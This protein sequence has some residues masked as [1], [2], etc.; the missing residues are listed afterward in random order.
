M[1]DGTQVTL[2]HRGWASL[3]D[4]HPVRHGHVGPDFSRW[5]GM[6]WGDLMTA[7]REHAARSRA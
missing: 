6:W 2:E 1:N 4:D 7:L 5:I 3:P